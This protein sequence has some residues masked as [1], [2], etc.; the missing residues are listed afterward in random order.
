MRQELVARLEAQAKEIEC[1]L[2]GNQC[3]LCSKSLLHNWHTI[4]GLPEE[5][6][7]KTHRYG[8]TGIPPE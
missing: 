5:L 8:P 3:P 1:C 6:Y 4:R 7:L 2:E